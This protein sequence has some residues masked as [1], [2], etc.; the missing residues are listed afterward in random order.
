M[1]GPVGDNVSQFPILQCN[2]FSQTD[3]LKLEDVSEALRAKKARLTM[4]MA[5]SCNVPVKPPPRAEAQRGA[6]V[7]IPIDLQI[8]A[9]LRAFGGHILMSSSK[10]G[11]YAFY[12]DAP[13]GYGKFTER[14]LKILNIRSKILRHKIFGVTHLKKRVLNC[15]GNADGIAQT[16]QHPAASRRAEIHRDGCIAAAAQAMGRNCASATASPASTRGFQQHYG[17]RRK[18]DRQSRGEAACRGQ[19]HGSGA[20]AHRAS[21]PAKMK[22][23]KL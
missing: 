18:T 4:V 22:A 19:I 7:R 3:G 21:H 6:E 8:Y 10:R 5:D 12:T 11:E 1:S 9:M 23:I 15:A 14:F 13:G 20:R 17:R 2:R 16:I